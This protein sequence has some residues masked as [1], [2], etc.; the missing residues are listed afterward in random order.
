[1]AGAF[2]VGKQFTI[3]AYVDDPLESQGLTLE[4]PPGLELV[5][6]KT[7]QAV[8]QSDDTGHAVVIWKA[9]V[10]KLGT[11][12][13]K[14]RSTN[15]VEYNTKL[16]I[17]EAPKGTS[18]SVQVQPLADVATFVPAPKQQP[19]GEP[20]IMEIVAQLKAQG[21]KNAIA[22]GRIVEVIRSTTDEVDKMTRQALEAEER[23]LVQKRLLEALT[24][25]LGAQDPMVKE[26]RAKL[27]E[28]AVQ[29]ARLN[30]DLADQTARLQKLQLAREKAEKVLRETWM[31][32]NPK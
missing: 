29:S 31:Q 26:A 23:L 1:M 27:E 14:I 11:H 9:R 7:T 30:A 13:I 4:L 21:N 25:K 17:E 20:T 19:G 22:Y 16:I 3:T 2:E 8:P 28:I 15:G 32:Q 24:K 12:A 10:A 6:G 5:Q 18:T